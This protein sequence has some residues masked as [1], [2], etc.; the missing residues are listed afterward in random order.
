MTKQPGLLLAGAAWSGSLAAWWG[1]VATA[2]TVTTIVV[3]AVCFIVVTSQQRWTLVA[4]VLVAAAAGTTTAT[5]TRMGAQPPQDI[6]DRYVSMTVRTTSPAKPIQSRDPN[7][8]RA[9]LLGTVTGYRDTA[10]VHTLSSH[11]P[12]AS[13]QTVWSFAVG[14]TA[15]L[16]PVLT[17]PSATASLTCR[18]AC[19]TTASTHSGCGKSARGAQ[20]AAL[21]ARGGARLLRAK[22]EEDL[23]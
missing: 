2:V 19:A 14:S 5:L 18:Q 15:P 12:F 10:G 16:P 7:A 21:A 4:A 13:S 8:V 6:V 20:R 9:T 23:P 1:A 22:R 11:V 17:E 3:A